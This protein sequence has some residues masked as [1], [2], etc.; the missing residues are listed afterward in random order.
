MAKF[1]PPDFTRGQLEL[2][3]EENEVLIYGSVTGLRKLIQ[4]CEELIRNPKSSHIHLEDYD[5]LT[6]N[7]LVG[8]LAIFEERKSELPSPQGGAS[9]KNG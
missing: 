1:K 6:P 5:V 4:F 9:L 7:S 2:R 3:Y 8:V